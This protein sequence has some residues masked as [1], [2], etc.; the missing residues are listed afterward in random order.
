MNFER[1][2]RTIRSLVTRA[3]DDPTNDQAMRLPSAAIYLY[4]DFA[5]PVTALEWDLTIQ[6]DPGTSVGEYLALFNGSIDGAMCYLGL[7]TDVFHPAHGTGIGKGLIFSTWW[8]NDAADTRLAPD[9][10]REQ[11]VHE[12]G[13]IGIRRPYLW[14]AGDYRVTLSRSES[15]TSRGRVLD[16]FD[17]WIEPTS[18][19]PPTLARPRPL[20][21]RDWIGGMRFP[22]RSRDRPATIE[23]GGLAFLEIYSGA[24]TWA[25]VTPW[26]VD[27]MAYG[28]GVRCPSG[29]IEYPR[30]YGR[31]VPNASAM[32]LPASARL[33][34]GVGLGAAE[35]SPAGR[36]A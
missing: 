14:A 3:P 36:W 6:I 8:S 24:Q 2:T 21:S 29:R 11:G 15:E 4:W 28:D 10:F 32:Y 31:D 35:K 12:G 19:I 30:P 18:P 7:Q 9:G 16:W 27:L 33:D 22:R 25:N 13:F 23:P 26:K 5:A 1:L 17:L 34:M 20:G